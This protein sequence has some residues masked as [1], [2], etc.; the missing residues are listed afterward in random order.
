M[1]AWELFIAV[2]RC[3]RARPIV[4]QQFFERLWRRDGTEPPQQTIDAGRAVTV[5]PP[6]LVVAQGL[7]PS[8]LYQPNRFARSRP[9]N[10][11][12]LALFIFGPYETLHYWLQAS[13]PTFPSLLATKLST[14]FR[15]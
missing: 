12:G 10:D 5:P 13:P 11:P 14:S 3:Y 7:C 1:C 6:L 4:V 15:V 8:R 2:F 9:W